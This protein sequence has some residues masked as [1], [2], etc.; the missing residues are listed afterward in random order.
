M[1]QTVLTT[2]RLRL[3]P[4]TIADLEPCVAMDLDP[5]VHRFIFG[6]CP[7]DPLEHRERLRARIAS[8]WPAEGGIWVVEW[9]H[10]SGFLGWCGLFP[11]EGSGLIEIGYRYL[12][13][14]WG[15]GVATEAGSTVLDHGFRALGL[16]PIVAVAARE[17]TASRRVLEKLGLG[18]RGLRFHYGFDLPFYELSRSAYLSQGACSAQQGRRARAAERADPAASAL[19]EIEP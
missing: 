15:R 9:R 10:T 2:E 14:A 19:T 4:R 17:N 3:R 7:P 1:Q 16:D 6:D 5:Q 8:G 18:Y 11:L 13:A 12:R